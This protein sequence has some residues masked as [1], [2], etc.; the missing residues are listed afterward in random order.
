MKTQTKTNSSLPAPSADRDRKPE[1]GVKSPN[2]I[3]E[4]PKKV[5]NPAALYF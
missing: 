4:K 2:I 1:A 3:A 5:W